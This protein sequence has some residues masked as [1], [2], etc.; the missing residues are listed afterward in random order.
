VI[1]PGLTDT[2]FFDKGAGSGALE[3]GDIA[4]AVIYALSQ[5]PS[6]DVNMVLVRPVAQDL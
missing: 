2:P 4:R 3:A 5:P 6:V 1:A